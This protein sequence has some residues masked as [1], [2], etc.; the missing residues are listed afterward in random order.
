MNCPACGRPAHL[1][2]PDYGR[3]AQF[4]CF[5]CPSARSGET[6]FVSDSPE[7]RR[8]SDAARATSQANA[9]RWQR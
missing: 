9:A 4:R 7:A 2:S 5:G 3:G 1:V 6:T 8:A